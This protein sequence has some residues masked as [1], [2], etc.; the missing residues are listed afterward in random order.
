MSEFE[1]ASMNFGGID[2]AYSRLDTARVVVFPVSY[3]GAGMAETGSGP[4]AIIDASRTLE[5]YEEES[6]SEVFKIG[7]HTLREFLPRSTAEATMSALYEEA[8]GV[9]KTGKFLC[10]LGGGHMISVPI[11]QAH[12]ENYYDLSVLQID[13]RPDLCGSFADEAVSNRS[14]MTRVAGE[15]RIPSVQVGIRSISADEIRS[16]ESGLPTKLFWAK[17][18]VGR[19]NWIDEAIDS[20]TASVY[21]TIDVHGLDPSIMP[22]A[23]R[24]EP[25]GLGWYDTLALIRKLAAKKP[26]VGM[27][28]V[29]FPYPE[30]SIS[31]A[32]LGAKLVYKSLAYIFRRDESG[33]AGA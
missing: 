31:G 1:R 9:I 27:D 10:T 33:P 24:P 11:I 30:H 15:M 2:A 21:L 32:V 25:G 29:E 14:V 12:A 8:T 6:N 19:T 13:A 17:D 22:V 5:L 7:I 23:E 26:V 3:G 16:L 4:I 28:L 18:I 20:L